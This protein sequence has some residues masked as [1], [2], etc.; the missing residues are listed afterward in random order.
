MFSYLTAIFYQPFFNILVFIYW[1]LDVIVPNHANMGVAVIILALIL[2]FLLLPMSLSGQKSEKER[3]KIAQQVEDAAAQLRADP[4]ASRSERRRIMKANGG[5]VLGETISL[6][7]QIGMS[8]LLWR[9][10]ETGL[11]GGDFHLLYDFL[12][13]VNLPFNL[14]FLN[15][16]NLTEPNWQ[17]TFILSFLIFILETLAV[18]HSDY[19]IT[20]K[21]VI[22]LQLTLPVLSFFIFMRLPA[23]KQLFVVTTLSCSVALAIYKL[24]KRRYRLY[25]EQHSQ[26]QNNNQQI[27]EI[28]VS[29]TAKD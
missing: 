2:R 22:R 15:R 10:F 20:R 29:Q 14:V 17:L 12:P 7:I 1:V 4:I 8:L 27:N 18:L 26:G 23:G 24:F 11:T 28:V 19:P 3:R 21:E 25:Q 9:M 5:L 16:I 6:L 13:Q